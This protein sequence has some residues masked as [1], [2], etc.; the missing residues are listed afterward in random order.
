MYEG[1]VLQHARHGFS[2]K[3]GDC[4]A[5]SLLSLLE[6]DNVSEMAGYIV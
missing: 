5:S 6:M 1:D 3:L 4:I 2:T